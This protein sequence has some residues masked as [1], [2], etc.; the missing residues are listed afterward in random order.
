[1][2][3]DRD[4]YGRWVAAEGV[5]YPDFNRDIHYVDSIEGLNFI[6]FFA[7]VDWGYKHFGAIVVI[8]E[9][10]QGDFYLVKE[11]ARQFEEIE[12]WVEEAKKIKAQY[13]NINFYCDTARPEYIE[14]FQ[15]EESGH[16]MQISQS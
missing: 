8:G 3:T 2:F 11:V 14:R 13:G 5:I 12:F 4:I 15:R 10:D 16:L 9:D 7:G 6:R 1:M